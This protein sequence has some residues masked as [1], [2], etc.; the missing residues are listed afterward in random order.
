MQ[1]DPSGKDIDVEAAQSSIFLQLDLEMEFSEKEINASYDSKAA[2]KH[3]N[4]NGIARACMQVPDEIKNFPF[5][6]SIYSGLKI[7]NRI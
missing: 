7:L 3:N 1:E 4:F 5:A 2:A 6:F